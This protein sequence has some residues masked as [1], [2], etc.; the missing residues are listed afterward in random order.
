MIKEYNCSWNSKWLTVEK[1][2]ANTDVWTS[3][4]KYK[5]VSQGNLILVRE[6][7][8]NC[9]LN[10]LGSNCWY[11]GQFVSNVM[12]KSIGLER[13]QTPKTAKL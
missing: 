1:E 9:Q 3:R 10:F 13:G 6:K 8:G 12:E 7:S 4:A 5:Y 2:E 11:P